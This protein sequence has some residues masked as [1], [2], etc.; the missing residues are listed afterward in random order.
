MANK[1]KFT[2]EVMAKMK[3][4]YENG[5]TQMQ[6]AEK[7]NT[8]QG[9]ISNLLRGRRES[10]DRSI[11]EVRIKESLRRAKYRARD[12]DV[13]FDI[14]ID[15]LLPLPTHCPIFNI[16]LDYQAIA[17]V[18]LNCASI[19]RVIPELGYVKGNVRIMSWKANKLKSFGTADEHRAIAKFMTEN[20]PRLD[21]GGR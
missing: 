9:Y 1:I 4:E 21:T 11:P 15:D 13:P 12:K 8:T 14:S 7:Y 16:E 6:L 18:Q 20:D 17:N 10:V 2:D 5:M 3:D 19:D